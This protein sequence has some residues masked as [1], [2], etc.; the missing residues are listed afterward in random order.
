MARKKEP[1]DLENELTERFERWDS[2]YENGCSDPFWADG[3]NLNLVRNHIIYYKSQIEAEMDKDSYPEIY[4][5]D[6]PEKVDD[7]YMAKTEEIRA[8]TKQTL[9]MLDGNSDLKYIQRKALSVDAKYA[10]S[11]RVR[12]ALGCRAELQDAMD[13]N[14]FI[15]M[16]R[17]AKPERIE[18][19]LKNCAEKLRAYVPPANSQITLFDMTE[20]DDDVELNLRL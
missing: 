5:R 17:L 11:A 2:I 7:S 14:D 18:E 16:R 1:V 13:K 10:E 9:D 20:E 12:A 15:A 4:Y 8:R 6:T 3:L 19:T